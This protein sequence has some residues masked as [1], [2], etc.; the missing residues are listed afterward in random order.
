M[1]TILFTSALLALGLSA[2]SA[3]TPSRTSIAPTG[4]LDVNRFL[5]R[6]GTKPILNWNITDP[7][8]VKA[9]VTIGPD[10]ELIPKERALMEVRVVGAA[11]QIGSNHTDLEFKSSI[12]GRSW[13]RLF[14]GND[15]EPRPNEP[16]CSQI[17]EP[18]VRIDFSARASSGKG[19]WYSTQDTAGSYSSS[20]Q[21]LTN[22]D[23]VPNYVPAYNQDTAESFLSQYISTNDEVTVGLRDIIYLV[24]LY[25]T[26]PKSRYFD[27]QDA[28][29]VVSFKEIP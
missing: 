5:V 2:A 28:V 6:T 17:V 19:K 23:S 25:A 11:F 29:V 16:V 15:S 3:G 12:G 13:N 24:E 4:K 10:G 18:G 26:N 14:H 22:G 7:K 8:N 20:I 21:A 27:M 9:L 1:K